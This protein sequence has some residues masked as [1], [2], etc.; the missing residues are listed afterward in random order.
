MKTC[1]RRFFPGYMGNAPSSGLS[2]R[3]LAL[4]FCGRE[5]AQIQSAFSCAIGMGEGVGRRMKASPIKAVMVPVKRGISDETHTEITEG[6][7]EGMEVVSGGY[8]AIAKQLEDGKAVKVDNAVRA[9]V[10]RD[11]E[12]KP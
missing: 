4:P 2:A 12:K 9:F 3:K 10:R 1:G 8:T 5:K 7:E 11:E 6:L